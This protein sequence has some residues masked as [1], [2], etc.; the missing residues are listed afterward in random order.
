[1]IEQSSNFVK[2]I[3]T[4]NISNVR[5]LSEFCI[6]NFSLAAH[7]SS[8]LENTLANHLHVITYV[9]DKQF[10]GSKKI[11]CSSHND[12]ADREIRTIT[13]GVASPRVFVLLCKFQGI[14]INNFVTNLL[15]LEWLHKHKKI[16]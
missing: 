8:W 13:S 11:V 3:A 2:D 12:K 7:H 9:S 14:I 4:W 10:Y 15:F 5:R 6:F 16:T 1:M